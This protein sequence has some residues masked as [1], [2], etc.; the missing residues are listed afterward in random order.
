MKKYSP[1]KVM[2]KSNTNFFPANRI[3]LAIAAATILTLLL[4][5]FIDSPLLQVSNTQHAA[6]AGRILPTDGE[7]LYESC[8][9]SNTSA[10]CL[11]RLDQM[12]AGGFKLVLNYNQMYADAASEI[13]YLHRAQAD[14]M[15]VIFEMGD[16]VFWNGTNLLTHF[17]KLAA[18][19]TRPDGKTCQNNTDFITFVINL[20][21]NH[22]ALWGYYIADEPGTTDHAKVK[23]Y[24][25]LIHQLDPNHPRLLVNY[26]AFSTFADTADVIAG[27]DYPIGYGGKVNEIGTLASQ[28]QSAATRYRIRSGMV[29]Q[30][31]SWQEYSLPRHCS[32]YPSC[33]PFPT[34]DQMETMLNLALANS[35]PRLILWYSY[36][37]TINW[38]S[39]NNTTQYW[40]DV[41]TAANS[42][43]SSDTIPPKV[44]ISTPLNRAMIKRGT[45]VTIT[46]TAS[47]NVG[48]TKV[49]F[50]VNNSLL[51]TDTLSPYSS[52]WNVPN[53]RNVTYTLS[54]KAYDA[55]GNTAVSSIKVT[56]G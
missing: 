46:A 12:S 48:V 45:K 32:P 8:I 15:K 7:G 11:A 30:A 33:A 16:A 53:K 26:Q 5:I 49:S 41:V 13:A 28:V 14:G 47:D 34:L 18:T 27:D 51:S 1:Q 3:F 50:Y 44:S 9:P 36:F 23:T 40:N 20:V 42:I 54:A 56:S 25:D 29:L 22:P 21:K 38:G 4:P 24:S 35:T 17:P 10:N 52:T 37:D 6:A 31:M 43:Y 19:C 2:G 39:K 55:A